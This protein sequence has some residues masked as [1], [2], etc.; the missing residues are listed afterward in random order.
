MLENKAA[1]ADDS[2]PFILIVYNSLQ[3]A[4]DVQCEIRFKTSLTGLR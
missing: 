2:S 3:L 4:D 1:L